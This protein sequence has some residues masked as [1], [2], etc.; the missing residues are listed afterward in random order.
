MANHQLRDYINPKN[1][2]EQAGPATPF[3]LFLYIFIMISLIR[4]LFKKISKAFDLNLF[5]ISLGSEDLPSYYDSLSKEDIEW[6][7]KEDLYSREKFGY[8]CLL[9]HTKNVL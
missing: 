9:P 4:N 8:E 1:A 6:T 5:V 3:L 2:F 7:L